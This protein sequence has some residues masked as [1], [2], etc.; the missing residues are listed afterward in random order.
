MKPELS[1]EAKYAQ[2]F[3]RYIATERDQNGE[4]S[5]HDQYNGFTELKIKFEAFVMRRVF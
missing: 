3:I 1:I 2:D 4:L 5:D